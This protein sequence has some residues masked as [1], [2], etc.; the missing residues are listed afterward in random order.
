MCHRSKL[1]NFSAD[2]SSLSLS[3]VERAATL[4]Y[5]RVGRRR[6]L[7]QLTRDSG[8]AS[9]IHGP[10]AAIGRRQ[11]T[12]NNLRPSS[13]RRRMPPGVGR[14]VASSPSLPPSPPPPPAVAAGVGP[15]T[16]G[17]DPGRDGSPLRRSSG[18][19][20]AAH[21]GPT[22]VQRWPTV[23]RCRECRAQLGQ[24]TNKPAPACLLVSGELIR[25]IRNGAKA[26]SNKISKSK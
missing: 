19:G 26:R 23:Q 11:T 12:A 18:P 16:G 8:A 2:Q 4:M 5:R 10:F 6:S 13:S 3:S 9:V 17:A 15:M 21:R 25:Q 1:N 24:T 20:T 22:F 7:N 14:L